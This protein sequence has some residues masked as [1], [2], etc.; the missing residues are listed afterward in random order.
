MKKY[1]LIS[2]LAIVGH[3]NAEV[4]PSSTQKQQLY[5]SF[6]AFIPSALFATGYAL[7]YEA[8]FVLDTSEYPENPISPYDPFDPRF[9]T[10]MNTAIK[11]KSYEP[12]LDQIIDDYLI[13][14][15]P[16]EFKQDLLYLQTDDMK[17]IY[18]TGQKFFE[19]F[20]KSR[21]PKQNHLLFEVY[22]DAYQSVDHTKLE[23]SPT[24]N[25]Y[26]DLEEETLYTPYVINQ[27]NHC[28]GIS[29]PRQ[30]SE[31]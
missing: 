19:E 28:Y 16:S 10:C 4:V 14:V 1:L 9:T 7:F 29:H 20:P 26:L 18:K 8:S 22:G 15:K 5:Q 30:S 13:A 12:V 23:P 6:E 27:I 25:K 2:L 17:A 3:A 21:T 11:Q 24:L 31:W